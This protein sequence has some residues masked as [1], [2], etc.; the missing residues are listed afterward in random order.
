MD[1]DEGDGNEA[2]MAQRIE[3]KA[4]HGRGRSESAIREEERIMMIVEGE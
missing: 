1:T 3:L 4:G 2:D